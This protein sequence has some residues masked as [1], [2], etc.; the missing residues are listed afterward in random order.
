MSKKPGLIKTYTMTKKQISF[1]DD[2]L[3]CETACEKIIKKVVKEFE[4]NENLKQTW[5]KEFAKKHKIDLA[6][7][8]ISVDHRD[9]KIEVHN[10]IIHQAEKYLN[11][12]HYHDE[13]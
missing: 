5:Y 1:F 3:V 6:K 13:S 7:D 12:L 11:Q 8:M 2:A 9:N 4:T 10:I